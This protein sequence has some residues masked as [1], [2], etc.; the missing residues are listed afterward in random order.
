MWLANSVYADFYYFKDDILSARS[1]WGYF[2]LFD[3]GEAMHVM[4]QCVPGYTP[5]TH[6]PGNSTEISFA[7]VPQS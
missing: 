6:K 3:H 5:K 4:Y 2:R 1:I 7:V